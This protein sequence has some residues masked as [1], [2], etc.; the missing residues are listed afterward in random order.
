MESSLAQAFRRNDEA[1]LYLLKRLRD[2]ALENRYSERTR[3]VAAQFAHVH[4]VRIYHLKRRGRRFLGALRPFERSAQPEK[5]ILVSALTDSGS[6]MCTFLQEAETQGRVPSWHGRPATFLGYLVAHEAHHRA[7]V[8][9]SMR[10]SCEKL[11]REVVQNIW[12][13]GRKGSL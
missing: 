11:P 9:L 2:E 5:P 13:W 3:T 6:A 4:N 12:N 7:L 10:I 8:I 1:N